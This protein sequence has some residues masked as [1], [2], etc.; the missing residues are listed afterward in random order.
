ML[1]IQFV[2]QFP[3]LEELDDEKKRL[4]YQRQFYK[5][6]INTFYV[7]I[8]TV[9]VV[10]LIATFFLSLLQVSG[11]SM[12]PTLMQG[13][14]VV[15]IKT[16][17]IEAGDLI[18]F[19]YQNKMLVKRVIGCSGDTIDIDGEG[20]VTVNGVILEETYI[21]DKSMGECDINLPC[22]VPDGQYFVLGDNRISSVDSRSSIV[23]CIDPDQIVGKVVVRILPLSKISFVN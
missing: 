12:E 1:S 23:G 18:S 13:D 8:T 21:K 19:Y 10:I 3:G 17:D 15:L 16:K 2:V 5:K 22:Q 6:L 14:V 4:L 20:N 9:A 7:M 11:V